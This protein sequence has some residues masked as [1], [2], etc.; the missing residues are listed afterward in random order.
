[1]IILY[2]PITH[3]LI[4][5]NKLDMSFSHLRWSHRTSRTTLSKHPQL[6]FQKV[7]PGVDLV[8]LSVGRQLAVPQ[9]FD[10]SF[11]MFGPA[12]AATGRDWSPEKTCQN[13]SKH[14]K[15]KPFGPGT[16]WLES[17]PCSFMVCPQR[18][19]QPPSSRQLARTAKKQRVF[20]VV[21]FGD[22]M[23]NLFSGVY[24]NLEN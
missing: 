21:F 19:P 24:R 7:L 20:S 2:V 18:K 3:I 14:V 17:R 15:T 12:Q 10:A 13:M 9:A 8:D 11:E 5:Y 4:R 22:M 23:L 16:V 6:E 1:M